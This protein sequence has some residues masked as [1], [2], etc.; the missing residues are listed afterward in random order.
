MEKVRAVYPN[1]LHVERRTVSAGGTET[2][3]DGA[4][5][6]PGRREA[7]P[8]E[9]FAA[10]YQEVKGQP[11]TAAK[12]QLFEEAYMGLLREEGGVI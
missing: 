7:N 3:L 5:A 1:A 9:L 10:F 11:L 4:A 6:G 12:K 8:I 2:S